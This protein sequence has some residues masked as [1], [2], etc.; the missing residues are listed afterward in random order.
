[1]TNTSVK[2]N[3]N[4][5]TVSHFALNDSCQYLRHFIISICFAHLDYSAP[6]VFPGDR[7]PHFVRAP[8]LSAKWRTVGTFQ[9][10]TCSYLILYLYLL[11]LFISNSNPVKF[12]IRPWSILAIITPPDSVRKT[13]NE[14]LS[15]LLA[16]CRSLRTICGIFWKSDNIRCVSTRPVKKSLC[17]SECVHFNG[18]YVQ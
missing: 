6:S 17:V 16:Y 9:L 7:S 11:Y 4:V 10:L 18:C 2:S 12:I 13:T 3:W 1:M 5:H 14:G 15:Y 8:S